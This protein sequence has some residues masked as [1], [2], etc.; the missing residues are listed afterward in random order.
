MYYVAPNIYVWDVDNN[1]WL[2]IGMAPGVTGATG[3]QGI[4]G[5]QGLIGD[6]GPQGIQGPIGPIGPVGPQGPVGPLGPTISFQYSL[7][8]TNNVINLPL[9]NGIYYQLQYRSSSALA[10]N[11]A[12]ISKSTYIDYRRQTLYDGGGVEASYKSNML[13]SSSTSIDSTIY[14][15]SREMHRTWIRIQDPNTMLWSTYE[16]CMFSSLNGARIDIWVTV[17]VEQV[18]Y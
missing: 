15:D 16:V 13:I 14:S 8:S 10:L 9:G 18:S 5:P 17:V 11:F 3:P 1:D 7:S 12:P 2:E 4:T 6:T